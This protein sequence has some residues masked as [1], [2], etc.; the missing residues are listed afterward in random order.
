MLMMVNNSSIRPFP[1][2]IN[3]FT[4]GGFKGLNIYKSN[5]IKTIKNTFQPR[6]CWASFLKW[7]N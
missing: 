2:Y 1:K 6:F 7:T 3:H 4:A 5:P